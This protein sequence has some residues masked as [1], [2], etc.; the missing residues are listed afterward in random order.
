MDYRLVARLIVCTD[1]GQ[2]RGSRAGESNFIFV[3]LPAV[4]LGTHEIIRG[5]L[6]VGKVEGVTEFMRRGPRG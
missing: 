3:Q 2:F 1:R 4:G 6:A 5:I